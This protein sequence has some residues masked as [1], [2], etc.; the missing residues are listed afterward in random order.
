MEEKKAEEV[1]VPEEVKA[2]EEVKKEAKDRYEMTEIVATT[3][4]AVKDN[5]TGTIYTRDD[6]LVEIL[7]KLENIERAIA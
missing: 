2:T 3:E 4:V 6:L 5:K 7:N 1:K